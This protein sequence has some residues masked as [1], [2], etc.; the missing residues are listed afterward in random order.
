LTFPINQR[1]LTGVLTV[2]DDEVRNAIRY[3]FKHLKLVI[4]PGGAV[5]LAAILSG[6]LDT[7]GK[8][9]AIV[10]SGGNIDVDL[11][12]EIQAEPN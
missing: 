5:A 3:A 7:A 12:A 4:E 11:F 6:K 9:T 10:L 2:T 8:T 1:L